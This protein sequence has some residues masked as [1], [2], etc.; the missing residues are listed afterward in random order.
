VAKAKDE[1]KAKSKTNVQAIKNKKVDK[2]D[3]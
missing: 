1:Y 3:K 2:R